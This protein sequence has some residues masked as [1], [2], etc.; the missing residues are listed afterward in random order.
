MISIDE[1][2]AID[3]LEVGPVRVEPRKVTTTYTVVKKGRRDS[4]DLAYRFEEDVFDDGAGSANLASMA[5]AQVAL[6]YG[7]FCDRIVFRG[8]FDQRDRKFLERFAENTA[9]EIY[10]NKFLMPNPFLAGAAVKMEAQRRPSYLRA[11]IEIV[12]DRP[13][14]PSNPW[15]VES[16]RHAVLSSGGKDSLLTLGLLR[17][18]E[19]EAHPIFVNESGRHWYTALN[20]YRHLRETDHRT[21]RVWTNSDRVFAWMLRHL[22]FVR[23]DFARVRSDEY[24][25]RLWTVA[26]FVFGAL[27]V[28]RARGIGRMVIGDEFD[29]TVKVKHRG[30]T[31]YNALY[32]QSRWFDEELT[33][34]FRR[35]RWGVCQFSVLRTMSE[36]LI[37]KTLAERY[38]DLLEHQTSCHATH[39]EGKRV[40]PCGSCEKCRRIVGMLLAIGSDPGRLGYTSEQ[41]RRCVAEL[42]IKGVH[43]E[44]AGAEQLAH[45][46]VER[47]IV[48]A[49]ATALRPRE[50]PETLAL[51]FHPVR[52]PV[53]AVPGDLRAGLYARLLEHA[54]GA[55]MRIGR[56]WKPYDPSSPRALTKPYPLEPPAG[57]AAIDGDRYLLAELTWPEAEARFKQVDVALLPVG[58]IEQ[59]GPHLPLDTDSYDA[60]YLARRVAEGCS[61]PRPLVLPLL[62]YGVSYHH[63]EFSGTLSVSPETVARIVHEIGMSAARCGVTKLV[64]V[65]GHG[66]NGPALHLAAQMINRDAHIFTCV[67]T[68]ETSDHDVHELLGAKNDVHAGEIETSTTLAIRPSLVKMSQAPRAVP[69]FSNSYLDFTSKRGV[70]WYAYTEKI[71]QTGVMGDATKATVAKG[72]KIWELMTGRL[73]ELVEDLKT[74]SLDEIYQRRY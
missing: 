57:S 48:T 68:G 39:I 74:L 69:R 35:K 13:P 46:L 56:V 21:A 6:N 29:T 26:V 22:P 34:W 5:T 9:R 37:E 71:S 54:G 44:A 15:K 45:M 33:R 27:P 61:T 38:P 47:S 25:I 66:G 24:P 58:A 51:R 53:E 62:P 50:R 23:K 60:D 3:T 43:Q 32:D 19:V 42:A 30:I 2:G 40:R 17:E 67:D 11:A 59:H 41:I 63:Q 12:D 31:H 8:V 73:V 14:A 18:M 4:I 72:E 28:L 1:L 36:L 64:I 20:A 10:V 70:G 65:N 52:S 16:T 7:L 55:V 49:D